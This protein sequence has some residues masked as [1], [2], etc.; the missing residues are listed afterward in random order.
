MADIT[1]EDFKE[2]ISDHLGINIDDIKPESNFINDFRIDSL[3]LVN[4]I[5]KLEMK[6]GIKIP[7]E[8]LVEM[9]DMEATFR[10]I[11]EAMAAKE[12]K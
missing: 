9:R 11:S 2:I 7:T 3:S 10:I 12:T 4:F 1:M 8:Q 5:I 6:L